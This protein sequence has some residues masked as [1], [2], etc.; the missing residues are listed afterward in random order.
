MNQN[1]DLSYE[2]VNDSSYLAVRFSAEAEVVNYQLAMMMENEIKGFLPAFKRM[3]NGETVIYYN[4]TSKIPL[5]QLLDKRK[6]KREE[7][8]RLIRGILSA[9]Q[10]CAEYRLPESGILL[11]PEYIYVNPSNCEPGV[12]FLP[13]SGQTGKTIRE[14]IQDLILHGKLELSNDN[15]IQVLLNALNEEPFSNKRLEECIQQLA[16][17]EKQGQR[18]AFAGNQTTAPIPERRSERELQPEPRMAESGSV[19]GAAGRS[20]NTGME[21][22][23]ASALSKPKKEKAER[24]NAE[25]TEKK[26]EASL[27]SASNDNKKKKEGKKG[28]LKF[29]LVQPVL[30]AVL[31]A[32]FVSGLFFDGSGNLVIN[33]VLAVGIVVL[34]LEVILYREIYINKAEGTDEGTKK[35]K[36]KTAEKKK[37]KPEK[38]GKKSKAKGK[39]ESTK[40]PSLSGQPEAASESIQPL[41][42]VRPAF[43]SAEAA[44]PKAADLSEKQEDMDLGGNWNQAPQNA[45]W[46]GEFQSGLSAASGSFGKDMEDTMLAE[47][48]E[49][50]SE[51]EVQGTGAP[52][53]LEFFENGSVSRI[54]LGK[55]EGV[56]IGRLRSQADFVVMNAR[57]GK[58][59]AKFFADNGQY[60]VVDINSKN[61]T[62]INGSSQRITSNVPYPL[63]DNDR[64]TLA[65]SEFT[66][67]CPQG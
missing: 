58:V 54:P 43:S 28:N 65:D 41:P 33:H 12:L 62:F 15:F 42:A 25:E 14:L 19:S 3:M 1:L 9:I 5:S 13:L 36:K 29:L 57:V 64:I 66:L 67:R 37:E 56:L 48:T 40:R 26:A 63:H 6:L 45:V 47:E 10:D 31:A 2:T 24:L 53:Y 30:L 21:T 20:F 32:A 44:R 55:Q 50:W 52:A 11:E 22:A 8:T 4:I 23:N 34:L 17:V 27:T 49:L 18:G 51:E 39:A 16:C 35:T 61:G 38:A 7:L 46:N 60:F 59:H